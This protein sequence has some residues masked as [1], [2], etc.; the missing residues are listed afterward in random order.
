MTPVSQGLGR[1]FYRETREGWTLLTVETE[2]NGDSRNTF[3]RGPS[4]VGSFGSSCR[5]NTRDFCPA[6]AALVA[7]AQNTCFLIVI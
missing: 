4:L 3:V 6:L 7:S 2:A 1:V 5:Y